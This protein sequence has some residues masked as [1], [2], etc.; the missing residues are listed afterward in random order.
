MRKL[1]VYHFNSYL[2][3]GAAIAAQ[4]LFNSLEVYDDLD[5]RFYSKQSTDSSRY[6][7]YQDLAYPSFLRRAMNKVSLLS[8]RESQILKMFPKLLQGRPEGLEKF[9]APFQYQTVIPD[10]LPDI[11]HLHWVSDFIDYPS[12]FKSIPAHIPV[13]WT[14][15]D[16]NPFTGGCHY[17][18]GCEKYKTVCETCPQ[19][20]LNAK[21]DL[22]KYC[23]E[24][25][26][27]A[28]RRNNLHIVADSEWLKKEAIQSTLFKDA[29]SF[30]CIHYGLDGSVFAPRD[31]ES[32]RHALGIEI[33]SE[34]FVLCFG[35]DYVDTKRKGVVEL[36]AALHIL[37]MQGLKIT[38]LVFGSGN[39]E[40]ID[41]VRIIKLGQ[42]GSMNYLNII[43]NAADLFVMPSL[44]EAFGQTCLEAMSCGVPVVGF[45]TGGIPDMIADHETGL[46]AKTGD[47]N[48]LA[49]KIKLLLNNK[50]LRT[51]MS[52]KCREKVLSEFTLDIQAAKY[53]KLYNTILN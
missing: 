19:L 5:T 21:F 33:G 41:G 38:C 9:D 17:T 8:T 28:F 37:K 16:M 14:L 39:F 30:Q 45:N 15:H 26:Q 51:K 40:N 11:I 34:E 47:A 4:R 35:A 6:F 31:K 22:A 43:Y 27:D 48:D 49:E 36:T 2:Y 24:T 10:P 20:G 29:R 50:E 42:V 13:V 32:C 3:G 44:E 46:L 18:N 1:R 7:R 25:K 12:F 52:V 23:F 53:Y